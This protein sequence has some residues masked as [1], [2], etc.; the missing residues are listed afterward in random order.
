[1]IYTSGS[2][3]RPKGVMVE[4]R[5]ALNFLVGMAG[6]WRITPEDRVLQFASLNFD[7]SVMDMF[8]TLL[9]G[10]RAVLAPPETLL[11]PPRLADLIRD[12]RVTFACMPPAIVNLLSGQDFP[13]LRL[14][15][16]AGEELSGELVRKWLRPGLEF[17]NGYGPTEA[18][19]GS[20]Y[21]LIDGTVFPP[22]IG[23]PKPNYQA[24]VL[25]RR[26][27]P[28]PVGVA[29]ELHVGG[30]GVTR[31]YLNRPELTEE[32]FIPDPFRPGGRL[33]KTG[34]LVRRMPD[35]NLV[36]LGRIDGQVKIRGLRVEPGEIET[37][38]ASHPAVAQAV[39]VVAPDRTGERQLAG[40]VRLDPE[41][42]A[43]SVADLRAH[44][45]GLLPAYMVPTYLVTVETFPLNPSGKI[46]KSA[47]PAPDSAGETAEYVA[48]RTLIETVLADMYAR[49]LGH[50]QVGIDDGFFDLGGNSL[51]AMQLITQIDA[52]LA[53]DIDVNVTAVFLAPSTR[54]LAELLRDEHGLEDVELSDE[55]TAALMAE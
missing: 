47:L 23:R 54:R 45:A 28:V 46:D 38:L 44:L 37:G 52:E 51:Q 20:C 9:A 17:Y 3:G 13:D 8:M 29:G 10:A 26:L 32:R 18:S 11:S 24:Y 15:L 34:D 33:Y 6:P 35:G 25:D 12:R 22:P 30:A 27:N 40:Y 41:G 19:I 36:F 14:V 2:T 31:G 16:S 43:A 55:E 5:H 50:D 53:A 21:S 4:H 1:V 49:L 48:P 39:V 7:V 42:P